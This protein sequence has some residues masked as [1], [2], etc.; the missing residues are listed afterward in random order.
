MRENFKQPL[1]ALF[2]ENIQ[3]IKCFIGGNFFGGGCAEHNFVPLILYL[4]SF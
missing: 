2:L 3:E 4:P 1:I